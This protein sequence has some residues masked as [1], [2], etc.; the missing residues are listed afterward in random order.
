ML[1]QAVSMN[2]RSFCL[3]FL[4]REA[5]GGARRVLIFAAP[6]CQMKWNKNGAATVALGK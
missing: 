2:L 3:F 1:L 4:T 5:G 6:S